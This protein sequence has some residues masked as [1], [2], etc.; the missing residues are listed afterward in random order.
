MSNY[1]N[2]L[3]YFFERLRQASGIPS[4][5]FNKEDEKERQI[6]LRK[7]KIYKLLKNVR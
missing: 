3:E 1:N 6:I 5:F 7:D 4:R 2:D